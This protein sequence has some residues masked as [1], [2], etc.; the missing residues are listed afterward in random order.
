MAMDRVY[1]TGWILHDQHRALLTGD[2]GQVTRKQRRHL[3]GFL[4]GG[5]GR[6]AKKERARKQKTMHCASPHYTAIRLKIQPPPGALLL[7][8]GR[9]ILRPPLEFAL[10]GLGVLAP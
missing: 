2:V 7:L 5:R 6:E 3:R 9:D 10:G 4:S 1:C 8:R